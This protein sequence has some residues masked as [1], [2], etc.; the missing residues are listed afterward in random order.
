MTSK[1]VTQLV[2][3]RSELPCRENS[4]D[5]QMAELFTLWRYGVSIDGTQILRQ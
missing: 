2:N 3:A 5:V 1:D 4:I